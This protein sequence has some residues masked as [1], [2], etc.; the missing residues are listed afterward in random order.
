MTKVNRIEI[1]H[2]RTREAFNALGVAGSAVGV[3]YK[4]GGVSYHWEIHK[5]RN[6]TL[7]IVVEGSLKVEAPLSLVGKLADLPIDSLVSLLVQ[8]HT[9]NC[10]VTLCKLIGR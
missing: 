1:D 8:S 7:V 5:K 4:S 2:L 9:G 3:G 6:G 10:A